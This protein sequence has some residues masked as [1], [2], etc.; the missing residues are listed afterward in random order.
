[1]VSMR[2]KVRGIVRGKELRCK[3]VMS[4]YAKDTV[5]SQPLLSQ[6]V[7]HSLAPTPAPRARTSCAV[8][9][10]PPCLPSLD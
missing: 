9:P 5:P 10:V 8:P 4:F 1:M 7:A 2:K 3:G 6:T